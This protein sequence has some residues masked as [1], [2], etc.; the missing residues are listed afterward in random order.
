MTVHFRGGGLVRDGCG[1]ARHAERKRGNEPAPLPQERPLSRTTF[2]HVAAAGPA[3]SSGAMITAAPTWATTPARGRRRP[4]P[5]RPR[6]SSVR[7]WPPPAGKRQ[8]LCATSAE[9]GAVTS[10]N[11]VAVPN[12]DRRFCAELAVVPP[13]RQPG[14]GTVVGAVVAIAGHGASARARTGKSRIEAT[15]LLDPLDLA[16]CRVLL[17]DDHIA[18]AASIM[19]EGRFRRFPVHISVA[20]RMKHEQ[21]SSSMKPSCRADFQTRAPERRA[22]DDEQR[23]ARAAG[24]VWVDW[25]GFLQPGSRAMTRPT[26]PGKEKNQPNP[27]NPPWPR[28]N[29]GIPSG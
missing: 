4:R 13:A 2:A 7:T 27:P 10:R 6:R 19:A 5:A 26:E 20:N 22:D 25:V 3:S 24:W 9:L 8:S 12:A 29:V 1:H 18:E 17:V 28:R 15:W 11:S 14:H 16:A 21:P 23:A